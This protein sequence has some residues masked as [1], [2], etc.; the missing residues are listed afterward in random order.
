MSPSF[1]K[2]V[3]EFAHYTFADGT[4]AETFTD[5]PWEEFV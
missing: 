1:A 4:F 3:D 5:L 2:A